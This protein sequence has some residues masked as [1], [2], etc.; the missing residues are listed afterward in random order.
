[1]CY[2]ISLEYE[3]DDES[4]NSIHE[5]TFELIIIDDT[6]G[7]TLTQ[8]GTNYTKT[9]GHV[10][11]C[12]HSPPPPSPPL[13]TTPP[14]PGAP[15]ICN[16]E[17]TLEAISISTN[18]FPLDD[19][20]TRRDQ[21]KQVMLA[22]L[23]NNIGYRDADGSFCNSVKSRGDNYFCMLPNP[24]PRVSPGICFSFDQQTY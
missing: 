2:I 14:S 15:I 10:Y 1:M 22:K 20:G 9:I 4:F 19:A 23:G 11:N 7:E 24:L 6:G 21:T 16:L 3:Y 12:L 18:F 13:P 5:V 8:Y 17:S